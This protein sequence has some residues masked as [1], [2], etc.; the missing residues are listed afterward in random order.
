MSIDHISIHHGW[1]DRKSYIQDFNELLKRF[2][3]R[4]Y[5]SYD[6][7]DGYYKVYKSLPYK[8]WGAL[9]DF[10]GKGF[11]LFRIQTSTGKPRP[12][13]KSDVRILKSMEI[14]D[15]SYALRKQSNWYKK[16]SL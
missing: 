3:R 9:G 4:V 11:F 10:D 13:V 2:D 5:C 12:P 14:K 16:Y 6:Y 1:F 7:D 8:M 15:P